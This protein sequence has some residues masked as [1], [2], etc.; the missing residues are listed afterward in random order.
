MSLNLVVP[1]VPPIAACKALSAGCELAAGTLDR[2][3]G[4]AAGGR[5]GRGWREAAPGPPAG[6][7]GE[8]GRS[9]P[10]LPA[11]PPPQ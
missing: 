4:R 6:E 5:A 2:K 8:G 9:S 3:Q 11:P 1:G 7:E 10:S